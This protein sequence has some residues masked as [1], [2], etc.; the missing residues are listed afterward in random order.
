MAS[1]VD[2]DEE[3]PWGKRKGVAIEDLPLDYLR[4]LPW[5]L[6]DQNSDFFSQPRNRGYVECMLTELE[7]RDPAQ[8]NDVRDARL[9]LQKAD[10]A[11]G[12]L[13]VEDDNPG[14]V[15]TV[16]IDDVGTICR[17]GGQTY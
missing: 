15:C 12:A 10:A 7:Q 14:A 6:V 9:A 1:T 8:I 17:D 5:A 13:P 16:D 11:R 4:S 2:R 3:L